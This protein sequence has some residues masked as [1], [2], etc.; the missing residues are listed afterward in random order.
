MSPETIAERVRRCISPMREVADNP[1]AHIPTL[2]EAQAQAASIQNSS[3]TAAGKRRLIEEIKQEERPLIEGY[4]RS[5]AAELR[6]QGREIGLLIEVRPAKRKHTAKRKVAAPKA[7]V[8]DAPTNL[9]SD[10]GVA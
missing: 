5:F 4:W 8:A 7:P 10:R 6:A 1:Q 3:F 9:S 2:A